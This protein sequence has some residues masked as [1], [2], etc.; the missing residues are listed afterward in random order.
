MCKRPR[1][2]AQHHKEKQQEGSRCVLCAHT[3][4]YAKCQEAQCSTEAGDS[5]RT[6]G[7][8]PREGLFL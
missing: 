1:F 2:N 6:Q 8:Y 3:R 7:R 4:V 5:D